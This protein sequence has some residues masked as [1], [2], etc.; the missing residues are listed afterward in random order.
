M[1]ANKKYYWIK[2]NT[3][4]FTQR[5]IKSIRRNE[6]GL[7]YTIIYLKLLLLSS[8]NE[9]YLRFENTEESLIDEIAIEIDEEP[10]Y[11]KAA[12]T[13][14]ESKGLIDII[15]DEE[16]FLNKAPEMV[17]SET[18]AAARMRKS[19]AKKK[20]IEKSVTMLPDVTKCYTEIDK[21]IDK[22]IDKE[23]DEDVNKNYISVL[24]SLIKNKVSSS[25]LK[26]FIDRYD[27]NT[28]NLLIEEIKK[29][30]YLKSN[31]NFNHLSDEFVNNVISGKYMTFKNQIDSTDIGENKYGN[32][33]AL[34]Y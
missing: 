13:I 29:S 17:G 4:F 30:N 34:E 18:K 23:I 21:D 24:N 6:Y 31:I 8:N 26:N 22:E 2:L 27:I 20:E 33:K 15:S 5:E 28:L 25:S 19:R 1:G 14:L 12:I 3:N 10:E 16:Y 9:G 7:L 32:T 11:V